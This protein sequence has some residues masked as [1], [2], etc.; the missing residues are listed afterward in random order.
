MKTNPET[1]AWILISFDRSV[2]LRR[3]DADRHAHLTVPWGICESAAVSLL[4]PILINELIWPVTLLNSKAQENW[5]PANLFLGQM[6]T[7]VLVS[8]TE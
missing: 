7:D 3:S 5:R 4:C 8:L 2:S 6:A 1:L